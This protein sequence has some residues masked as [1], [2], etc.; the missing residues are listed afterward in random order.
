MQQIR[1]TKPHNFIQKTDQD[2]YGQNNS[3]YNTY[4]NQQQ[5]QGTH[6]P[7]VNYGVDANS[8]PPVVSQGGCCCSVM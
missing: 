5:Q 7:Y 1:D 4:Y 3:G 6:R 2:M 8:R